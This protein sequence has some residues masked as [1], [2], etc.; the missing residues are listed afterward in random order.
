MKT[1]RPHNQTKQYWYTERSKLRSLRK[2]GHPD[3]FWYR[4]IFRLE[5]LP[6]QK[7]ITLY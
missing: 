6:S 1:S 2:I 7:Q 3:Y 4:E 5:D